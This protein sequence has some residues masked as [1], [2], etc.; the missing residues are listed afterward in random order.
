MNAEELL[1]NK[2]VLSDSQYIIK[3]LVS[4][5]PQALKVFDGM[6]LDMTAIKKALD[7][8]I[9]NDNLSDKDKSDLL[10]ETW[11]INYRA[12]IP[13]PEE[14]LTEKYLGP[15][16]KTIYPR[17][18]DTFINFLQPTSPYRDLILYP[19]ISWGKQISYGEKIYT[20]KGYVNA[21]D[22]NIGDEVCT[23]NGKIAKVKLFADY[24]EEKI[25]KVE[26][27]DGRVAYVGGPHNWKAAH[28]YNDKIKYEKLSNGKY[29]KHHIKGTKTPIWKIVTTLDIMEDMKNN[30]NHRW[31]LPLTK[32]VYFQ[33]KEHIISPY[34]LGA[35]LGGGY[36]SKNSI[37]LVGNDIEIFNECSLSNAT[38]KDHTNDDRYSVNYTLTLKESKEKEEFKRLGLVGCLSDTKFIPEEYLYD[39]VENRISLLQGL[40]DTDGTLNCRKEVCTAGFWTISP[41][42]ADDIISLVRSLGGFAYK[43]IRVRNNKPNYVIS[44]SFPELYFDLFR[45]KRKNDIYIKD[46]QRNLGYKEKSKRKYVYIKSITETDRV[47]GR[48]IEI[49]DDERLYLTNDYVVTHNSFLSTLITLYVSTCVSLMRDPYKYFG[50]SPATLLAQLLI[51]YSIKKSREVL[52][53]PFFNIMESSPFFERVA[54]QDT[55]KERK[56]EFK[57]KGVVDKLYFTTADPDS[58]VVFDSGIAIKVTSNVQGLLG[59]SAITGTLSELAFFTD[60]GKSPEYILRI[61]NDTKGRIYSRMKGNPYGI[62]ILDSS[63]NS[64]TNPIDDWIVNEAYKNPKN[65]IVKGSVWEWDKE[66]YKDDFSSGNIFRVFTGG[67][68]QPPRI[69]ES[70]DPLLEDKN[71]DLSKI[72]DVPGRL[73]NI[74]IDDLTKALKD[75]AGL[76]S[77]AADNIISDY[78]I[79]EDMFNNDLI[80]IYTNIYAPANESPTNLIWDKIKDIF[81]KNKAGDYEYYYLPGI[82]RCIS[83]DQSYATDITSI[84]MAHIERI[85]DSGD[86]MY[87]VDFTITIVPTQDKINLEAIHCFIKDLRQLGHIN[88]EAVSFDQ[89][90]SEVTIQNLKRDGFNVEKLSVDRTT[91]PY[92]NLI[93]YMN[94]RQIKVGKN[95]FLKNNLK[96]L[97]LVK[98]Q[99]SDKMK[100]D[101]DASRAQVIS[102][103]ESWDKSFIGYFGKDVSDSVAAVIE[104]CGKYFTVPQVNWT[105]GPNK[106][107]MNSKLE[108]TE[109]S[110]KTSLLL[111]NLGLRI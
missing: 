37:R 84:S 15:T 107:A 73:K 20:P 56:A 40:M 38:F 24:P 68:G 21:E 57:E 51:S 105:G 46:Y 42:L 4:G 85:G 65:Y 39:S 26:T 103:D 13:T 95:I 27:T 109:A 14:F 44:I 100:I 34:T 70:D 99:K 36:I 71:A 32:P 77:G 59:L 104:L 90:Q 33:E 98:S 101:H 50:L 52:L 45:L 72:I 9:K 6:N 29:K 67:K 55:M 53:K 60:A 108:R 80:N 94:R 83:V 64:L 7:F 28:N 97:H 54:R 75:Y 10:S 5:D 3:D 47:G 22:I 31:F 87:V 2:K 1:S 106:E 78:S 58:E 89:F 12:P 49:D 111:S 30:P 96:C 82:P 66:E 11:R 91:G 88:I 61:Y 93:S 16:A 41:R 23:P 17:V 79:I 25:Y 74:F 35:F 69:L 86:N 8:I 81:F 92:L 76:P 48:C 62:S 18:K 19:H 63:P 110:L 102:G 43:S